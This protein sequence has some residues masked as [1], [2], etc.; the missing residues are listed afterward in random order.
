MATATKTIQPPAAPVYRVTLDLSM[1]EA[2]LLYGIL[3]RIGGC[4]SGRRR[5]ATSIRTAL[6]DAGVSSSFGEYET[7][8]CNRAIYFT[9]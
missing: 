7:E 4:P 5:F 2:E 8:A 9:K 1:E 6:I 3:D